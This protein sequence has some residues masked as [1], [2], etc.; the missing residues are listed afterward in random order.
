M[1]KRKK[2][3]PAQFFFRPSQIVVMCTQDKF[4]ESFPPND[5]CPVRVLTFFAI[6]LSKKFPS[7]TVTCEEIC[8][9]SCLHGNALW[10]LQCAIRRRKLLNLWVQWW[11]RR[12][13]GRQRGGG[14]R[15]KGRPKLPAATRAA[16][17][18]LTTPFSWRMSRMT[19]HG[20]TCWGMLKRRSLRLL[21]LAGIGAGLQSKVPHLVSN[22]LHPAH[23]WEDRACTAPTGAALFGCT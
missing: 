17:A 9:V 11:M 15:A 8:A 3:L 2:P 12:L 16:S 4:G 13:L 23:L 7:V 10:M 1:N 6:V 22:C 20:S 18:A 5:F 21:Q 14:R 19:L